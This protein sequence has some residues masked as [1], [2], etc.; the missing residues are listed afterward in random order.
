MVIDT[1][2][3]ALASAAAPIRT[4]RPTEMQKHAHAPAPARTHTT[5]VHCTLRRKRRRGLGDPSRNV[6]GSH[7][8]GSVPGG[9]Y[10]M[11]GVRSPPPPNHHASGTNCPSLVCPCK[12]QLARA[13]GRVRA[14]QRVW[15]CV[16]MFVCSCVSTSAC[17]W[18][19]W[20][21]RCWCAGGRA[22]GRE[23]VCQLEVAV[24]E[25]PC[26]SMRVLGVDHRADLHHPTR[27]GVPCGL[28]DGCGMAAVPA[29]IRARTSRR[30][31]CGCWRDDCRCRC[32]P[33]NPGADAG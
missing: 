6:H 25:V 11:D 20:Q 10:R 15:H 13:W 32:G 19:S 33:V 23:G 1:S 2:S 17:V 31:T 9:P 26:R 4:A 29:E 30:V 18:W 16:D 3:S 24:V 7:C 21:P 27:H 8:R 12:P 5:P 14:C 22:E 28:A